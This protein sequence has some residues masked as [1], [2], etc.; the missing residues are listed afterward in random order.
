VTEP[1]YTL[2]VQPAAP[3]PPR[4]LRLRRNRDGYPEVVMTEDKAFEV[5]L[6]LK[7]HFEGGDELAT[8]AGAG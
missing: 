4:I 3:P 6:V 8:E 1:W 7:A 5:Y 2:E